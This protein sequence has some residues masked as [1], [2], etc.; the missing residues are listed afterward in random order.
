MRGNSAAHTRGHRN[1]D[2]RDDS[3]NNWWVAAISF[4]ESWY[5]NHHAQPRSAAHGM[6]RGELDPICWAIC[7]TGRIGLATRV[8]RPKPPATTTPTAGD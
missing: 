2:T 8:V 6:R 4:G 3:R 5:N 1:F 7:L